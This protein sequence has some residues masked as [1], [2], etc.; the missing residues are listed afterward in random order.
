MF[1]LQV[2]FLSRNCPLQALVLVEVDGTPTNYDSLSVTTY[3]DETASEVAVGTS[4]TNVGAG[5]YIVQI[6]DDNFCRPSL[7]NKEEKNPF[8]FI[9]VAVGA[10]EDT[11]QIIV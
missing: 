4:I 3:D 1:E 2:D 11:V 10:R 9:S 8:Y 6:N 7:I 5:K